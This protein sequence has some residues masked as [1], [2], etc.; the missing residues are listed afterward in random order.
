MN[1][2][3]VTFVGP[4]MTDDFGGLF[5]EDDEMNV[6]SSVFDLDIGGCKGSGPAVAD[7]LGDF[8]AEDDDTVGCFDG[9]FNFDVYG[10]NFGVDGD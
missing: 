5:A 6:L 1:N 4:A 2:S 7:D 3:E 9:V 10:C 8:V